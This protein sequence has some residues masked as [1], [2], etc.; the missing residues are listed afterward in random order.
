MQEFFSIQGLTTLAML[1]L[2]QAVLGFDNLLYISIESKRAPEDQ[3][4]WVRRVGIVMA[5]FLRIALLLVIMLL[6]D[7]VKEPLFKLQLPNPF[8]SASAE[9]GGPA[10]DPTE[11][12]AVAGQA[13]EAPHTSR[14]PATS[15][16][17]AAHDA[18][19]GDR[20][21]GA[22]YL[23]FGEFTLHSIIT[24]FGGAFILYTAVKEVLHLLAVEHIEHGA[25]GKDSKSVAMVVTMIVIMNLVFSFDSILSAMALT[26]HFSRAPAFWLMAV[27]VVLSGVLMIYLADTVSDFLKKNRMYE[28]L[29]LF[30]LFI[31]GVMLLGEGGHLAHLT[32]FSYH[33]EPMAKS[34]FYFT[35]AV[36]VVI[37][38]VQG[39]YRK[40]LLAQRAGELGEHDHI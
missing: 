15:M 10:E 20:P 35:L 19:D 28:V 29:G 38:I 8:A 9:S 5:I 27:A 33:V 1:V 40:K 2:L 22:S 32:L 16:A 12:A 14:T 21:G 30:I 6:I 25:G 3:Q 24:L 26:S 17:Q 34:T 4:S 37:D 31:V 23:F 36:L 18:H 11:A 39:R 7:K 13:E